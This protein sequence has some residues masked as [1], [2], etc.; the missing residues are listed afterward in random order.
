MAAVTFSLVSS[1]LE[2]IPMSVTF[3]VISL[4]S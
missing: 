3:T 2:L 1:A 4:P